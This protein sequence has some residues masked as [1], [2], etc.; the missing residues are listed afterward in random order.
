MVWG[1]GVEYIEVGTK[2]PTSALSRPVCGIIGII[3]LLSGKAIILGKVVGSKKGRML[4][5][6]MVSRI[7]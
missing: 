3:G 7:F 5:T 6:F 4:N 2:I 1:V